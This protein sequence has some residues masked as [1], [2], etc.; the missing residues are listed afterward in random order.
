MVSFEE[1]LEIKQLADLKL[2]QEKGVTGVGLNIIHRYSEPEPQIIVYVADYGTAK[3]VPET[4]GGYRS[5]WIV[6]G[7]IKA[8]PY[9]QVNSSLVGV[10]DILASDRRKVVRPALGGV[11]IG[12]YQITAGTLA[13]AVYGVFGRIKGLSNN[14]VVANSNNAKI[15]DPIL[16]PGPYPD[17]GALDNPLGKL[18]RFIPLSFTGDNIVDCGIFNPIN[19]NLVDGILDIGEVPNVEYG[20]VGMNVMKSG[21]TSYLTDSS[22]G[23]ILGTFKVQYGDQNLQFKDQMV[24]TSKLADP[25]DSGSLVVNSVTKNAVGLLF[26]GSN[27]ITLVN[28]IQNVMSQLGISIT[29]TGGIPLP[30][31]T[32]SSIATMAIPFLAGFALTWPIW[33]R[34]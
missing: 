19:D 10:N 22:F 13:K 16:Q 2:L 28:K 12:H 14:H 34:K 26:A 11:S 3:R 20:T 32:T 29:S 4:I 18:E 15:G 8:L 24:T 7:P 23:D 30:G 5:K 9:L 17:G 6:T 1:V 31:T 27:A 21:R 33:K 25:G